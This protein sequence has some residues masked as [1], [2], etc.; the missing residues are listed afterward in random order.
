VDRLLRDIAPVFT[1]AWS[2]ID[3]QLAEPD[4]GVAPPVSAS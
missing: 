2:R 1:R 4:A 3:E